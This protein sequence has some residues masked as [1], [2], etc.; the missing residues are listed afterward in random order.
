MNNA[1]GSQL[2][3]RGRYGHVVYGGSLAVGDAVRKVVHDDRR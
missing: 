3:L 1:R 2:H